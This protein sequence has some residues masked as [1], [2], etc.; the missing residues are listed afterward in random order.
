MIRQV[1][2]RLKDSEPHLAIL[3]NDAEALPLAV[4]LAERWSARL[5]YDAHEYSPRQ[6]ENNRRWRLFF[7]RYYDWICRAHL[8]KVDAMMTVS[9]GLAQAY[10]QEFGVEPAV[11]TSAPNFVEQNP[12][13]VDPQRIRMIHHGAAMP[14]HNLEVMIEMMEHVDERFHLDFMLV[15][16]N[17]SYLRKLQK[18][19]KHLPTVRF[20]P[21]VPMLKIA[22]TCNA[23][24]IGLFLLPPVN[25]NYANA[26]PNKFFEFVQ[27]R[28]A[29]AIGPS[30]DMQRL[31]EQYDLGVVS[32]DF[33]PRSLARKLN[34]L[35]AAQIA[36]FKENA[37]KAAPELC[38][39]KNMEHLIELVKNA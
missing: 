18:M 22:Q 1:L 37:H 33:S 4:H 3:A 28:L 30:Q 23:Y 26:L 9:Q 21:P 39:E 24:D 14:E 11:V 5:I 25:F 31:V 2:A 35:D 17:R 8:P 34:Q 29:I 27:G 15:P 6:F 10:A 16:S 12:T 38:A 7:Q 32:E 19:A 13:P 36:R 20:V